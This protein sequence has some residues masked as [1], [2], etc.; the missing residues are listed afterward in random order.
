MAREGSVALERFALRFMN[1]AESK[2]IE[3]GL[4]AHGD[5]FAAFLLGTPALELPA[6]EL[7]ETFDDSYVFVSSSTEMALQGLALMTGLTEGYKA[8][9]QIEKGAKVSE[10]TF[11]Y[12]ADDFQARVDEKYVLVTLLSDCY[13]FDITVI[14]DKFNR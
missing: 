14:R 12:R 1:A 11:L 10:T 6:D 9:M 3:E 13:V 8:R 7:H 5:R 2:A 4:A